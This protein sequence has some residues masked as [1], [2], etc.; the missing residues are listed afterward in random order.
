MKTLAHII[1]ALA[2]L[3][4]AAPALASTVTLAPATISVAAGQTVSMTVSVDTGQASAVTAKA[5]IAYP[6]DMLEAVSFSFAPVWIQLSQPGY[7]SMA[8]GLVVKTAGYPG[9]FTGAKA[10][11][12]LVFKAKKAGTA[13][14]AVSGDSAVWG[15]QG[16]STL[17]GAQGAS[18]ITIT[19]GAPAAKPAQ[20]APPASHTASTASV[21]AAPAAEGLANAIGTSSEPAAGPS[22]TENSASEKPI[23][24][25]P[26]AAA[27]ADISGFSIAG[28]AWGILLGVIA[29]IG[30]ALAYRR[31]SK[32]NKAR[33]N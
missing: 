11:G 24:K 28:W 10:L 25:Q 17:S 26:A 12:T 32:R 29:A 33:T 27:A 3:T 21:E 4:A 18:A 15:G 14:V 1:I 9:G 19:S 8:G 31:F 7:D 2:A 20:A 13:A 5:V 23:D 30:I 22:A 6:E 16:G